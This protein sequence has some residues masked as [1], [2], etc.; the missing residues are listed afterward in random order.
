MS[1]RE[2]LACHCMTSLDNI[3]ATAFTNLDYNSDSAK[4]LL[5]QLVMDFRDT[6]G[7]ES[8]RPDKNA[9]RNVSSDT[10][11]DSFSDPKL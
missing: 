1:N 11:D 6:F 5:M 4:K 10:L 7:D 8:T 2:P 9:F 3:S